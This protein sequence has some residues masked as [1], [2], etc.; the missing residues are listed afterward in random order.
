[1]GDLILLWDNNKVAPC[2]NWVLRVSHCLVETLSARFASLAALWTEN[3]VS[4]EPKDWLPPARATGCDA[5]AAIGR[6]LVESVAN[7]ASAECRG[8]VW[9]HGL[10]QASCGS[11]MCAS[12]ADGGFGW[13]QAE[14]GGTYK[15]LM[16]V[17]KF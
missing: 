10:S 17:N 16:C 9:S 7:S 1:M 5:S 15:M 14:S 2:Q 13:Q 6:A 8:R 12:L 11:V 4:G 3:L